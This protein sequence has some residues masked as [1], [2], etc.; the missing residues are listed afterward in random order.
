MTNRGTHHPPKT[1]YKDV[2]A[3]LATL[4]SGKTNLGLRAG[5]E[6]VLRPWVGQERLEDKPGSLCP[7]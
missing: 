4:K 3:T 5:G 2:E 1:S 7:R 6:P